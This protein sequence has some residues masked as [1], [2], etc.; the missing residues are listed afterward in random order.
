M[1]LVYYLVLKILTEKI[2]QIKFFKEAKIYL[3]KALFNKFNIE[4]I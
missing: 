4:N 1:S 3:E 2:Q